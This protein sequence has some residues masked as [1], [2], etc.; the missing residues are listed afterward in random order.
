LI[1]SAFVLLAFAFTFFV[2]ES[3]AEGRVSCENVT[4]NV[5]FAPSAAAPPAL[6][7]TNFSAT[8]SPTPIV[9]KTAYT[10]VCEP[11]TILEWFQ[12]VLQ[13]FFSGPSEVSSP[14]DIVFGV[15]A[16]IVLLNVVIAIV[17]GAWD[18]TS[19]D[20]AT[21]FWEFRLHFLADTDGAADSFQEMARPYRKTFPAI[22]GFLEWID[23]RPTM[24]FRDHVNWIRKP[25]N[26]IKSWEQYIEPEKYFVA[27]EV[28][29]M[30]EIRSLQADLKW[31]ETRKVKRRFGRVLI[32]LNWVGIAFQHLILIAVGIV[33][34]GWTWPSSLRKYFVGNNYHDPEDTESNTDRLERLQEG[35][36]QLSRAINETAATRTG[37]I[38]AIGATGND[39]DSTDENT[40]RVAVPESLRES[41]ERME[42]KLDSFTTTWKRTVLE[43]GS[44]Y[45]ATM[46]EPDLD[47]LSASADSAYDRRGPLFRSSS[48][49]ITPLGTDRE[50]IRGSTVGVSNPLGDMSI[51]GVSEVTEASA[52]PPRGRNEGLDA[53]R[54]TLEGPLPEEEPGLY[55]LPRREEGERESSPFG[56]EEGSAS[57]QPPRR[58]DSV[59]VSTLQPTARPGGS[60][61]NRPRIPQ[62]PRRDLSS[63]MQRF[64]EEK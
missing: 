27:S 13:G 8:P 37:E 56:A 19:A 51:R 36:N 3:A 31:H 48:L 55:Q 22:W 33:T 21:V 44:V 10:E 7:N 14:L 32:V 6:L 39:D 12:M 50:G 15:L 46:H 47:E 5:S 17:S 16:V 2:E 60:T 54:P 1:V 42:E 59:Q 25:F 52:F 24:R 28:E 62:P 61:S 26:A 20:V 9:N 30:K 58:V 40:P 43:S 35:I 53:F 41:V 29:K 49:G 23:K 34:F 63:P 38:G 4:M 18:R 57:F 45:S 64:A 11:F